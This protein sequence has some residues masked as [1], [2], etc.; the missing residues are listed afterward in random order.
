MNEGAY[1][2]GC[3]RLVTRKRDKGRVRMTAFYEGELSESTAKK[4][5]NVIKVYTNTLF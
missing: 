3:G 5:S 1:H 2:S 4:S